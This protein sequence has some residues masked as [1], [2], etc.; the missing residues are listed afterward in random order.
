MLYGCR[1][2]AG[3]QGMRCRA[4]CSTCRAAVACCVPGGCW[5]PLKRL[6]HLVPEV[7][8]LQP[9]CAVV[10]QVRRVVQVL[11]EQD[12]RRQVL[13]AIRGKEAL[14]AGLITVERD[15]GAAAHQRDNLCQTARQKIV[16]APASRGCCACLDLS[17]C[18]Q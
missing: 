5:L 16:L 1:Q 14:P 6:C 13:E 10:A 4:A 7:I 9:G 3:S 12:G 18:V 8:K 17:E 11:V 15:A 2:A